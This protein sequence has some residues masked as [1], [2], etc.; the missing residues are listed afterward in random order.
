MIGFRW[1][2]GVLTA[3]AALGTVALAVVGGGFRRSL[4][5]PRQRG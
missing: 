2:I 3:V 4:V 1:T 5:P